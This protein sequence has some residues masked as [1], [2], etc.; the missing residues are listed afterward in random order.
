MDLGLHTTLDDSTSKQYPEILAVQ[1]RVTPNLSDIFGNVWDM[2][3]QS[4]DPFDTDEYEVYTRDYT[5]P[6]ATIPTGTDGNLWDDPAVTD[7]LPISSGTIDRLTIGD[8]LLV[9]DEIVVVKE[10]DRNNNDVNVYERGAGDSTAAAHAHDS[11]HT[12]KIIGNSHIE[13]KVDAEAMA[14]G[15]SKVT[16]YTQLVEEVV[17]LS[18]AD[19]AQARKVGRTEPVLKAEALERIMQDLARTSVYGHA[20]APSNSKPS[21]TRGLLSYLSDVSGGISTSVGGSYTEQSLKNILND[22]RETGGA[23]PTAIVM[24][25]SRKQDFN[26][27]SG[28][29]Q[30]Q[31][32]RTDRQGGRII[33]SY[34]WETGAIPAVVDLDMPDDKV[35]V[36]N[37]RYMEKGWKID[38]QLRFK[39]ET[40]TNSREKKETLQGRFGLSV[41][42][43]GKAHGLLTNLS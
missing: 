5:A 10:I 27:F 6:E 20:S 29:D 14:E 26:T 18:H 15:T 34:L 13:G 21:M 32:D 19:S 7:E 38:D 30:V 39:E 22:I 3:R 1:K 12:A 41:K 17:D 11:T 4:R 8:I 40:N 37:S 43:I 24:S 25:N 36:I 35:A 42:Q 9:G 33:D 2:F 28:A 31:T 16:N 23:T